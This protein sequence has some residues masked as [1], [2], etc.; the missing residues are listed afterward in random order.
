MNESKLV[1]CCSVNIDGIVSLCRHPGH[2]LDA[3]SGINVLLV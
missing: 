3:P 2:Y 1:G